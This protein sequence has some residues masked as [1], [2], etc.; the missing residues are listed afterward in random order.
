MNT[1]D[2]TANEYR[3]HLDRCSRRIATVKAHKNAPSEELVAISR[4][5]ATKCV[6]GNRACIACGA[7]A[8]YFGKLEHNEGCAVVRL[9]AL[10]TG[11]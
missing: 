1:A 9:E 4:E 2:M 7:A 6:R 3:E 10:L 8:Y 5:L 11:L